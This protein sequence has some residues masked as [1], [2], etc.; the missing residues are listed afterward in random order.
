MLE[1]LHS[2][3]EN[4]AHQEETALAGMWLFLASE[5]LLFGGLFLICLLYSHA[6]GSGWSAAVQRTNI[7]IGTVNTVILITSSAVFTFAVEGAR[8]GNNRRVI[9]GALAATALGLLFLVLKGIEWAHEF[10]E[11]LFPGPHFAVTGPD[12]GGAA[13]Y[14]SFY[15]IATGLHGL[16]LLGG[17]GLLLWICTRARR[18]E[19]TRDWNTPVDVVGLYWSFVDLMWMVLF[20][21]I[22]LLGRA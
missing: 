12:A 13:L 18:G 1:L 2:P 22:Y 5:G 15:F 10:S 21:L 14:Y 7:V 11:N 4:P 8:R 6:F 16:H 17:I 9:Q 20:P 3:Y 19:F